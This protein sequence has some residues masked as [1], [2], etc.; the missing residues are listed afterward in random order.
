MSPEQEAAAREVVAAYRD[1]VGEV[2][3]LPKRLRA[4][5]KQLTEQLPPPRIEI[6]R[7]QETEG[8]D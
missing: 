6:G 3:V 4:A 1:T 5:L 2:R 8:A 7:W